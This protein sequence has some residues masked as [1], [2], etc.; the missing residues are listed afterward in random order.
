MNNYNY[1]KN[2]AARS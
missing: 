2:N 1:F